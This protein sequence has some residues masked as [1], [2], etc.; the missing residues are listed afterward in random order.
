MSE[1]LPDIFKLCHELWNHGDDIVLPAVLELVGQIAKNVPNDDLL[2]HLPSLLPKL[3]SVL[4][5]E[6]AGV[7]TGGGSKADLFHNTTAVLRA[8]FHI[9]E[10]LED[11]IFLVIPALMRLINREDTRHGSVPRAVRYEAVK[12]FTKIVRANAQ[13]ADYGTQ[14]MHPLIRAFEGR[15]SMR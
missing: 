4:D 5:D 3:I 1:Q 7:V 12:A 13:I 14:I 11:Y 9:S 2:L 10:A 6:Y 8:L 15:R